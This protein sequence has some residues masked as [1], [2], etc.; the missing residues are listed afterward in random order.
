[1]MLRTREP[2]EKFGSANVCNANCAT[3]DNLITK[4]IIDI[5]FY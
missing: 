2:L 1:M 4:Q 3:D 5:I